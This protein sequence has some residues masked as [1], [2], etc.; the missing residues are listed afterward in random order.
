M[1]FDGLA[2]D[3]VRAILERTRRVAVVGASPRPDRPS[4]GVFRFLRDCGFDVVP[5]NPAAAGEEIDGIPIVATLAEAGPLDMVDVF[6]RSDAVAPVAD[7]AVALGAR[8]LW[9]Q[10]G[11]MDEASA[12]RARVAGLAVVMD[13]C[14][15]IEW[16]RLGLGRGRG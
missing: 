13:R 5:V 10:L 4:H 6:R 14:P 11:V 7:E 1:S 9:L 3:A 15:R 8:T 2:D 16:A 12:A